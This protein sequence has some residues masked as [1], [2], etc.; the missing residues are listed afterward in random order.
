MDFGGDVVGHQPQDPLGVGRRDGQ[1]GIDE[2]RVKAVDPHPAIGIEHDLGH[3]RIFQPGQQQRAKRGAQHLVA[4]VSSFLSI[5]RLHG[6]SPWLTGMSKETLVGPI[7]IAKSARR[8]VACNDRE[9]VGWPV[10]AAGQK[11]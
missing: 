8:T 10:G 2:P 4:A 6:A 9:K 11:G 5:G 1:A 7:S 3:A